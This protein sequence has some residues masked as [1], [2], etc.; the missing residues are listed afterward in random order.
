VRCGVSQP[1]VGCTVG[2]A[3]A[4]TVGTDND[5]TPDEAMTASVGVSVTALAGTNLDSS[6]GDPAMDLATSLTATATGAGATTGSGASAPASTSIVAAPASAAI[7]ALAT[8]APAG[9]PTVN[10]GGFQSVTYTATLTRSGLASQPTSVQ[11]TL[12][13]DAALGTVAGPPI[14]LTFAPGETS[15]A[16]SITVQVP[17]TATPGPATYHFVA[18]YDPTGTDGPQRHRGRRSAFVHGGGPGGRQRRSGLRRHR[19]HRH[20]AQ[21]PGGRGAGRGHGPGL[22]HGQ[23]PRL[24]PRNRTA[25]LTLTATKIDQSQPSRWA[26]SVTDGAGNARTCA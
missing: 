23:R 8:T 5:A 3:G 26:F 25:A 14:T 21:A 1:L 24:R 12:V 16:G 15:Q 22:D 2:A 7:I 19:R 18:A 17:S 13:P 4:V 20:P 11:L 6:E 9:V 10:N